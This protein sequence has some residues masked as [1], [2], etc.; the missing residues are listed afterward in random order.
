MLNSAIELLK[1]VH[2]TNY[3]PTFVSTDRRRPSSASTS[4][5]YYQIGSTQQYGQANG[6]IFKIEFVTLSALPGAAT[7]VQIW[8]LENID[9]EAPIYPVT[10]VTSKTMDVYLK[11]F[12]FCNSSGVKQTVASNLY[13]VVGHKK[14]VMP[15]NW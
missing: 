9:S 5:G 2:D 3:E 15:F 6:P 11:K 14:K 13:T 10:Y 8:G 7:H 4:L 12:V 1:L